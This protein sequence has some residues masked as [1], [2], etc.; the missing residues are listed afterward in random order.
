MTLQRWLRPDRLRL[1]RRAGWAWHARLP[2]RG[3]RRGRPG[4]DS[5]PAGRASKGGSPCRRRCA[6]HRFPGSPGCSSSLGLVVALGAAVLVDRLATPPA[7]HR[8]SVWRGTARSCTA[9]DSDIYAVDPVTATPSAL[10]VGARPTTSARPSRRTAPS[11]CS[12]GRSG[13]PGRG[14]GRRPRGRQRRWQ[15]RSAEVSRN[16]RGLDWSRS[17]SPDGRQHRL[18]VPQGS[19]RLA[20]DRCRS[21]VDGSGLTTLDVGRPAHFVTWLP[22]DGDEI[23]F[24][25]E[26][27]HADGTRQPAICGG[28]ARRDR[29]SPAVHQTSDRSSTTTRRSP[30]RPMAR[31]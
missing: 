19:T 23:V 28:P 1:A 9:D 27:R 4:L 13:D 18:P 8:R 11:C 7:C 15:R 21:T 5:G 6:S 26:Q 25:G 17:W 12:C 10:I 22:P 20:D 3:P 16:V 30:C 29:A 2:R 24:R 31:G 14:C